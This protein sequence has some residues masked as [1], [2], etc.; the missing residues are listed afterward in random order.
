LRKGHAAFGSESGAAVQ[1]KAKRR[2][3]KKESYAGPSGPRRSLENSVM[4]VPGLD[5]GIVPG[6]HDLLSWHMETSKTWMAGHQG[7][8]A[9]P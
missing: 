1:A 8:Y 5:P 3:G 4:P 2:D 7:V 6:I 9:R